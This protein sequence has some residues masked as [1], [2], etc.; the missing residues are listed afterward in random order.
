MT[1]CFPNGTMTTQGW[2]RAAL[3][4]FLEF[5]DAQRV[6][7]VTIFA[8]APNLLPSAEL[9]PANTSSVCEWFVPELRKWA[10]APAKLDDDAGVSQRKWPQDVVSPAGFF[11]D[12]W[13]ESPFVTAQTEVR[14]GFS[15]IHAGTTDV[16][17]QSVASHPIGG[18]LWRNL[19]SWLDRW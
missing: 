11:F 13:Q 9:S 14:Q 19:T 4:E 15:L 7:V 17:G 16:L 8:L 3:R 6:R 2:T 1:P 12:P 18:P 5:L 10:L